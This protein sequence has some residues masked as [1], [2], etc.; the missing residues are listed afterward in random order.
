MLSAAFSFAAMNAMGHAAGKLGADWRLVALARVGLMLVFALA[1]T[2][3][4]RIRV[5][6]LRPASL[7]VRSF[8]GSAAL[9]CTFYS[10]THLSRIA[11]A[12][13]LMSVVPV[14]VTLFS[15]PL[16]GEKP[17]V[18]VWLAVGV[19]L[20]GVALIAQPHFQER[21]LAVFVALANSVFTAVAVLGL[22][23]L[24]GVDPR[25]VVVHF[26]L[27]ATVVAGGVLAAAGPGPRLAAAREAPTALLLVGVGLIGTFGQIG[28]TRAFAKGNPSRVA[29]VGLTQFLFGAL[30]DLIVWRRSF[31]AATLAGM[32][33]VAAPTAWLL[34]RQAAR[35]GRP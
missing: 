15:W 21:S 16:F 24:G 31:N 35:V 26:S 33:L 7:W 13:M 3:T 20:L 5:P 29:V 4:A 2:L 9:L 22:H 34:V 28:L 8:A 32:A 25:A 23:T 12:I 14:W 17:T 11:D 30:F 18:K 27:V 19:S 1:L 6:L 10:V